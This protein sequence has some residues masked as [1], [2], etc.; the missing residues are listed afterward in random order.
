M[1]ADLFDIQG[2]IVFVACRR[3]MWQAIAIGLAKKVDIIG[4]SANLKIEAKSKK[5]Y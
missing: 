3:G 4:V 5:K 1:I 2:K